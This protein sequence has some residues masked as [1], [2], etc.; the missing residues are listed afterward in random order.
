MLRKYPIGLQSFRK[1]REDG[2]IY[3]DKTEII[4]QLVTT[5]VY[6]FLSRP[7][8]FGKSLLL[9]TIEELFKGNKALFEGLWIYDKWNWS[10]THPVI[11]FNFADLGVRTEGLEA[12]SHRGLADNAAQLGIQL[13]DFSYDQQFKELIVKASTT[14]GQV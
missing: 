4:Y 8:R 2:Y 13:S 12:A 7:R 1:I 6:Y 14:H 3:I 11:L 5:G 10:K 9:D